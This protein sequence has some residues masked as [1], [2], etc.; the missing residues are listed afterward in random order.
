MAFQPPV[1]AHVLAAQANIN[2]QKGITDTFAGLFNPTTGEYLGT[3][4]QANDWK[5]TTLRGMSQITF[6]AGIDIACFPLGFFSSE[7]VELD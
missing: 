7:C 2:F 6:C 3:E 5:I 1:Y 4:G